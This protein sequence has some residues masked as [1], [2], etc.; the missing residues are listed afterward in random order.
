MET[1]PDRGARR[2]PVA[3]A[4]ACLLL[5]GCAGAKDTEPMQHK[6]PQQAA[7]ELL[8][9]VEQVL[10]GLSIQRESLEV[11]ANRCEGQ[12]GETRDDLFYVW[13][14]LRGL[15]PGN[16]IARQIEAAHAR[17]Q[18]EGWEIT[19]FRHLDSGGVNLTAT[20]PASGNTYTLDSG[21]KPAPEA[22]LAAFFN[23]P[24][25]QSPEGRVHFGELPAP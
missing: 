10:A 6:T 23:T 18:A 20:D 13:V 8:P 25:F 15:A 1:R 7:A 14:G 9:Q 11:R 2:L 5:A 3:G 16:D 21:F 4:L 12:R 19:R 24:C 22:Y 17:W